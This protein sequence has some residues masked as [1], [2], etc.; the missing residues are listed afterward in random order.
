MGPTSLLVRVGVCLSIATIALSPAIAQTP[1]DA[2]SGQ[3]Q[4]VTTV[5]AAGYQDTQTQTWSLSGAVNPR[6]DFRDYTATWTV[7]GSGS[8]EPRSLR[9]VA[10]D[11]GESWTRIGSDPTASLTVYVPVGT[12]TIR[13]APGQKPMR[14]PKGLRVASD[15]MPHDI[16]EWRFLPIDIP[17]G[18]GLASLMGSRTQT[19]TDL[20]G[21]RQPAGTQVTETCTWNLTKNVTTKGVSSRTIVLT[22]FTAAGTAVSV[23]SRTFALNG[24]TAAG[25]AVDVASRTIALPGFVASGTAVTVRSRTIELPGFTAA[26]QPDPP[27]GLR[28]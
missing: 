2:W 1:A 3:V 16:E 19:R 23:A 4:C 8:R 11:A 20:V 26:G 10:A 17:D 12:K 9:G 5:D 24:F 27:R 18:S 6:N 28:K 7:T 22:G 25:T 15:A 14:I 13:I 21:W